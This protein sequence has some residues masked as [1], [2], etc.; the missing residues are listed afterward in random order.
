M[1]SEGFQDAIPLKNWMFPVIQY[2][3]RPESFRV[4]PQPKTGVELAPSRVRDQN[5]KG[6]KEWSRSMSR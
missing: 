2:Q 6:L 3:P 1:L 4:A 5:S